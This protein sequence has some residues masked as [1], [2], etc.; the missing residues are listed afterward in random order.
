MT[1]LALFYVGLAAV[2]VVLSIAVRWQDARTRQRRL[3]SEDAVKELRLR[4]ALEKEADH[5]EGL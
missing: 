1:D 3:D 4:R 2:V 5:T